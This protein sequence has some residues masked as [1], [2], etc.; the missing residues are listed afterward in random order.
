MELIDL[1]G[2]GPELAAVLADDGW[3]VS[4][5]ATAMPQQLIKYPGIGDRTAERVISEARVTVNVTFNITARVIRHLRC[6]WH[7]RLNI[8]AEH[9]PTGTRYE[10]MPG[11]IGEIDP[12]DAQYLLS[13]GREQKG[14]CS[15]T[16]VQI[17][18]MF[19]E[20]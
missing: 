8:L 15:G 1:N 20:V 14:C 16:P 2:I 5:I 12:A 7:T 18:K 6:I 10:F 13:L 9:T 19:E 11:Q 4:R 17:R 3:T